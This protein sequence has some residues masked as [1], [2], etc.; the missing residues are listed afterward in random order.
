VSDD[1]FIPGLTDGPE[2]V[3]APAGPP[4]FVLPLGDEGGNKSKLSP[5]PLRKDLVPAVPRLPPGLSRRPA[6]PSS[7]PHAITTQEATAND[8][9][10][11]AAEEKAVRAADAGRLSKASLQDEEFPALGTPKTVSDGTN[12]HVVSKASVAKGPSTPK[13]LAIKADHRE[14]AKRSGTQGSNDVHV[15][16]I[17]ETLSSSF[18]TGTIDE[19]RRS[20]YEV[21]GQD[22]DSP[23]LPSQPSPAP[24]A[25]TS[26]PKPRGLPKTLRL[27]SAPKTE[28]PSS[29]SSAAVTSFFAQSVAGRALLSSQR[30]ET[31]GSEFASDTASIVSAS[32]SASRAGS[33]PPLKVGAAAVRTTTK[34]QQRKQRKETLKQDTN[35]IVTEPAKAELEDHAPVIGRKKKQRR[36]KPSKTAETRPKP[37]KLQESPKAEVAD[38]TLKDAQKE[39]EA[40]E[41]GLVNKTAQPK[42]SSKSKAKEVTQESREENESNKLPHSDVEAP[43]EAISSAEKP[44]TGPQSVF[45]DIKSSLW[46][47]VVDRLHMLKPISNTSRS[48]HGQLSARNH[49]SPCKDCPCKCGEIQD[50]DLADLRAGKAVRKQFHVDG[51][52]MLITPNGDCVRGLTP[53]EEDIFLKLQA[54]IASTAEHPGAFVA[55]RHQPGNGAFSLIKGRAVPNGRPNIFP[56]TPQSLAQDPIG[57]LQREDALSYIN[58]YVLP[59][60]NLGA[61]NVGLPKGGSPA[62]DVAAASLN[63]LAP[64]FY[65]PDA[66]AGVGIYSSPDGARAMQDFG[67]A[68]QRGD[69]SGRGFANGNGGV[70]SV[71]LMSAEDAEAALAAARKET[72]KLEKGLNSIIKRNKRLLVSSGN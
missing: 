15:D 71:P 11:P 55:P 34:S 25:T 40:G 68:A 64:Y 67:S 1:P 51:S 2:G 21:E 57:K 63:S 50:G 29:S 52:R 31:P 59:R 5:N 12:P 17:T 37:D 3:Q 19:H 47:S 23:G 33:P 6:T 66:A 39:M 65:G 27:V 20:V 16:S 69:E 72:E 46:T 48:D 32:V 70:G 30:P 36:E 54:A 38:A 42:K 22:P 14:R 60:L 49:K 45:A 44:P 43:A 7:A 9:R 41:E 53:E 8:I 26:S 62:R 61:T 58:Q 35:M 24:M 56:A 10:V 18:D 13:K 28:E 4:G